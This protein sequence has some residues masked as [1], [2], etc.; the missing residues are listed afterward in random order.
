MLL[1]YWVHPGIPRS[2]FRS[3]M[4]ERN[5]IMSGNHRSFFR[6]AMLSVFIFALAGCGSNESKWFGTYQSTEGQLQLKDD[7]KATLT[8]AGTS[9]D[10]TWE[11]VTTIRLS[12]I[13]GSP[14]NCSR[15]RL[16][17][18]INRA[19]SGRRSRLPRCHPIPIC[20]ASVMCRKRVIVCAP[21]LRYPLQ[22]NHE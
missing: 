16:A 11:M 13:S 8:M 18:A 9:N 2:G 19:R 22:T 15:L 21:R 7:H 14:S 5:V 20:Y 1:G 4:G 6:Y 3:F 12:F 17:C 10:A